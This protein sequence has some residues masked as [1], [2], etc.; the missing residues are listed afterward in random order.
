MSFENYRDVVFSLDNGHQDG[1]ISAPWSFWRPKLRAWIMTDFD[2]SLCLSFVWSRLYV[3]GEG[4]LQGI[5][6]MVQFGFTMLSLVC[7]LLWVIILLILVVLLWL[8]V[9]W[10][11]RWCMARSVTVSHYPTLPIRQAC[12]S[13][14]THHLLALSLGF[15]LSRLGFGLWSFVVL[16][17]CI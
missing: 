6:G 2:H 16:W 15:N 9:T 3:V 1:A 11:A 12:Y 8:Q 17:V 14:C 7:C 13:S 4:D 5:K 10:L